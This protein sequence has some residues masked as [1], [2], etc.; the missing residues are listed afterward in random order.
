MDGYYPGKLELRGK[1]YRLKGDKE[2]TLEIFQTFTSLGGWTKVEP[3]ED[4]KHFT[5]NVKSRIKV[6]NGV[7]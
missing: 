4:N 3:N 2:E 6:L 1:L 5:N 7:R